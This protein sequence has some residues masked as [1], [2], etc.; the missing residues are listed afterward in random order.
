MALL[1]AGPP[2]GPLGLPMTTK[3]ETTPAAAAPRRRLVGPLVRLALGLALVLVLAFVLAGY[4]GYQAGLTQRERQ[5]SATQAADL[6]HQYDLGVAD[7]AAGR[8]EVAIARFEY[9]LK[10]DPAYRDT[11]RKLAEA[12]QAQPAATGAATAVPST[13]AATGTSGPQPGPEADAAEVFA[14]AQEFYAAANWNGVIDQLTL[15]HS[16]DPTYQAVKSDGMLYVA[17]RN[18]GIARLLGDEMEAGITDLDAAA[19][20]GPLDSEALSYRQWARMYLAAQSYWGVDWYRAMINLQELYLI[21]P[22]FHD[23]N[24]RLYEATLNYAK[25]LDAAGDVCGAAENYTAAL[26]LFDDSAV[27]E[28]AAAAQA[29]CAANPPTPEG[30]AATPAEGTPADATPAEGTAAPEATGTPAP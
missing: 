2:L 23:T 11:G 6:A 21:A 30:G 17:L 9:I 18:R 20:F 29:A 7:L 15:L 13:A 1:P 26:A 5:Y 8:Y 22:Y 14:L 27:A 25:Q 10:L 12:R 3:E 28:Q 16:I 19:E 4:A 24:L